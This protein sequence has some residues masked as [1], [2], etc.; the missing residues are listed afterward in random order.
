MLLALLLF[1]EVASMV[2]TYGLLRVALL[3]SNIFSQ[4]NMPYINVI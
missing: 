1:P 2:S 4:N 3:I